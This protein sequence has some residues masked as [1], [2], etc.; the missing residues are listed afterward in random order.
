MQDVQGPKGQQIGNGKLTINGGFRISTELRK[1][2]KSSNEE[3]DLQQQD[4]VLGR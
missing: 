2:D 4:R 3:D 1:G